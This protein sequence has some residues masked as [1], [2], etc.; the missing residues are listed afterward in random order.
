MRY[1]LIVLFL[2]V[3]CNSFWFNTKRYA[4][5]KLNRILSVDSQL[6]TVREKEKEKKKKIENK[7][8]AEIASDI[9]L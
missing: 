8:D 6:E 4:P 1:I 9:G 3:S 5:K 2:L 7:I